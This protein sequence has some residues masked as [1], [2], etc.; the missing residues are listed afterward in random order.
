MASKNI[1]IFIKIEEKK[2]RTKK[3]SKDGNFYAIL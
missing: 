1:E 3:M 2:N